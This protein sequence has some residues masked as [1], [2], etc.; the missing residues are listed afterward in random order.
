MT[1]KSVPEGRRTLG[2]LLG[3]GALAVLV[4]GS[5][6]ACASS[7]P[8]AASGAG[9]SGAPSTGANVVASPSNSPSPGASPSSPAPASAPTS[10][11][12]SSPGSTAV[13][14]GG[15]MVIAPQAQLQSPPAGQKLTAFDSV[16]GNSS[17]TILYAGLLSQGGACGQYDV[18]LEQSALSVGLGLVHLPSSSRI[19]PMYMG[20]MSV[21]AK[22][23]APLD[24]RPVVDL[25]TG[26]K[27]QV[28]LS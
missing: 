9:S 20:H 15:G 8:T 23:S 13:N 10:V 17:G 6:A 4:A 22:L 3:A 12:P 26:Q 24:G 19:C 1:G 16:T 2:S 21:E 27:V 28:P 11:A 5:V 7:S 14:P 25:A 18:V